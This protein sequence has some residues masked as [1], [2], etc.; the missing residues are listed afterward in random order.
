METKKCPKCEMVKPVI[1]YGKNK[2][3]DDG[4]QRT[5]KICCTTYQK[6]SYHSNPAPYKERIKLMKIST[7]VYV[8]EF[9]KNNPCVKCGESRWWILD[10]HHQNPDEKL[11]NIGDLRSS[12]CFKILKAEIE[13]CVVLCKN[14]HYDF[15]HQERNDGIDL[16]TFLIYL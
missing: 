12:G 11:R 10:F 14:C 1:E 13:K 4:L 8:D 5:C 16:P 6:K 2:T 15:H 3:R 7:S 9:R